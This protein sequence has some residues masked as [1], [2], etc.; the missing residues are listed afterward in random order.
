LLSVGAAAALP[1][2]AMLLQGL[3]VICAYANSLRR[4]RA[5]KNYAAGYPK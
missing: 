4:R 1:K 3:G 2:D 5:K